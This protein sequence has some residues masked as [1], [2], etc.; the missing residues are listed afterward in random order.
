MDLAELQKKM[1]ALHNKK[2]ALLKDLRKDF[3][4]IFSKFF[5]EAGGGVQGC[6]A[7]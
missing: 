1:Q 4:S 5:D 7:V 6:R 2:E 3:T